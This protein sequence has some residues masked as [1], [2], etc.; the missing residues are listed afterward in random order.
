MDKNNIDLNSF[1]YTFDSTLMNNVDTCAV[2]YI[3]RD[4]RDMRVCSFINVFRQFILNLYIECY[5]KT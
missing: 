2:D 5:I 1:L 4:I 3:V